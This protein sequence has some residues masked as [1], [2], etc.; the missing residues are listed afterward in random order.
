MSQRFDERMVTIDWQQGESLEGVYLRGEAEDGR[1]AVIAPPHPL[2]GGSLESPVLNEVA[3][4]C[5]K[6]GIASL[7]FNWRGVGASAGEPS[8]E[9]ADADLDYQAALAHLKETVPGPWLACGYSFGAATAARVAAAAKG[10]ERLIL[11]APPPQL[12]APALLASL[13]G[14]LLV[15]GGSDDAIAPVDAYGEALADRSSA[16]VEVIAG[17]DHFFGMGLARIGQITAEWLGV[18]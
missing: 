9:A 2:Y 6:A 13:P 18:R 10:I 5:Q 1:G 17:A 11:V 12:L 3:F 16:K 8:G 4:A 14:R 7:R 15:I